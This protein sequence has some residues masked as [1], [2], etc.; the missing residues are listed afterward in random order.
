MKFYLSIPLEHHVKMEALVDTGDDITLMS[1]Q[2]LEQNQAR[3]K[4]TSGNLRL[5][6]CA[7]NIQAYTHMG[8]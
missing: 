7:L 2:I 1:T 3:T 4:R 5:Q 6:K 8:L